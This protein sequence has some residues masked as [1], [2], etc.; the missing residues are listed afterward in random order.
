MSLGEWS[1]THWIQF[2]FTLIIIGSGWCV[3]GETKQRPIPHNTYTVSH[4]RTIKNVNIPP[5]QFFP[6]GMHFIQHLFNTSSQNSANP[7]VLTK[8]ARYLWKWNTKL[9]VQIMHILY[10]CQKLQDLNFMLKIFA[11]RKEATLM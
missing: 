9:L 1:K 10:N 3:Q 2:S 11:I 8:K 7:N 5:I 6:F 4:T